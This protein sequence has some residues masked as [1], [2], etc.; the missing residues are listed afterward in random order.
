MAVSPVCHFNFAA[1]GGGIGGKRAW[2][3][4]GYGFDAGFFEPMLI[5]GKKYMVQNDSFG[6]R[7]FPPDIARTPSSLRMP[8]KKDPGIYRIFI[9]GES[10]A[11]GDPEPAFGAGRYL[12]VLLRERF[13]NAKFEVVNV[14]MTAI[15]SHAILPIAHDCARQDGD[16]WI[17]YMGNN[18]MVGPFGAATVFGSQAPPW[19][20]VRLNLA[21]QESRSGQLLMAAG[22]KLMGKN[23]DRGAW[24]GMNMFVGNQVPPGDPR[25]ATVY[26]NFDK[27]LRDILRAGLASGAH[28]LLSTV[29]VNLKD[30]PPFGS[31][32]GGKLSNGERDQ[33]EQIIAQGNILTKKSEWA[34]AA[35]C[36]KHAARFNPQSA[37]LEFRLGECFWEFTNGPAARPYFEQALDWDCLPFRADTHINTLITNAARDMASS[38]LILFDAVK[39]LE[40][41]STNVIPGRE[42]FYEHV[43]LNF[44]G[45]YRLA[46]DWAGQTAQFLPQQFTNGAAA[47][48]ASQETCE[49]RLGLTD[50][51]RCNVLAEACRR[52]QQP[53]LN[54]QFNNA[55][56]LG[57]LSNQEAEIRKRLNAQTAQNAREVYLGALRHAPDDYYLLENFAYFLTDRG[58]IA[59]ATD[60]WQKS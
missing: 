33:V 24:G 49:K 60:Q 29:A 10:A 6:F 42:Y 27:N 38:Q 50:W 31:E 48:W 45:N 44:D 26:R 7:F 52:M 5:G 21:I 11:L 19:Q 23:S 36:Y 22:R 9:L 4:G 34:D 17:I 2:R 57:D 3:L 46:R 43:H 16:L 54:S 8:A 58:D 56:R 30:C 51:D 47:A 1:S 18:E 37:E 41:N 15:N 32:I 39:A 59:G 55:Q 13:P 25:K 12:E 20:M 28:I 53:P 14:A 35:E 40:A